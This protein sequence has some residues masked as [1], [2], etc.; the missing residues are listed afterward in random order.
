V[1]FNITRAELTAQLTL[2]NNIKGVTKE[3]GGP[4]QRHVK[5]HSI[6]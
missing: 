2:G 5:G 4:G 1:P 3:P 6:V